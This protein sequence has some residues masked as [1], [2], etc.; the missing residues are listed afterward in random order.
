K[1]KTFFRDLNVV[2]DEIA[3]LIKE[4]GVNGIT[5]DDDNFLLHPDRIREMCREFIKRGFNIKWDAGAHVNILMTHFSDEDLALLKQS[6]CQQLYI[7]AESG[8]DEVL[9]ILNKRATV[10]KSINY[11]MRMCKAGIRPFLS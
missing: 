2:L 11:V 3:F 8:S 6:G 1:R 5:F 9:E 10:A 7:G 4:Y